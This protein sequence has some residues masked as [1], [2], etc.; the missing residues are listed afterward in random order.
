MREDGIGRVLIA[1]LHQ[2]IADAMPTRIG[3]Y[4]SWLSEG[5]LRDGTIGLAPTFA[6]LSFLRQEGDMYRQVTAR[7]GEY[8]AQWT[9]DAMPPVQRS[10]VRS[11]PLWL[12]RRALMSLVTGLVRNSYA[13][14]RATGRVR[15]GVA[16]IGIDASIFCTV[17]EP[18]PAPLCDFYAAAC[19]RLV[20]LFD[21]PAR[22]SMVA[23][24]ATGE[25]QC[26]LKV[27]LNARPEEAP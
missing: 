24:R 3:F 21:L 16:E 18:A 15:H 26:L 19:T 5:G 20:T 13:G 17:R 22:A 8:A 23:C 2:S 4:E 10:A 25:P 27:D 1:S 14:S 12:R 11:L 7:A 6:V 9:V